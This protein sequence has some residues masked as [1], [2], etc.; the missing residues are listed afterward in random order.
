MISLF[1][2]YLTSWFAL[3]LFGLVL[4][5]FAISGVGNTSFGGLTSGGVASVGGS[6]ISEARLLGEFD[7]TLR[8]ARQADPKLDARTAA[9][10]GAVREVY[11]QLI[12]TT[13]I[14]KF[15][16]DQ[17]I[18]I[19]DRAIDGE[20]ASVEAFQVNGV[21]DQA[22]YT[23]LLAAQRLSERD[24][25]DGLRS[26]LI[27]KQVVVPVVA[28]VK[29]P[30]GLAEPYAALLLEKREG[31]VAVVPAAA[32]AA[33]AAPTTAQLSAFYAAHAA[34]Y[35]LPER[36][37]FR[38]ALLD[39]AKLA[40][41]VTISDADVARYFAAN[42]ETYAGAETRKLLQVV[43]PDEAKAKAVAGAI[44]G[45]KSFGAAAAAA[46]FAA[47]DIDIGAQTRAKFAAATSAA[48]ADAAFALHAGGV[49][50]P[51]QSPF[52]WH[53]VSVTA[54]TPAQPRTLAAARGEIVARLT[55]DRT[56]ALLS[57]TVGKIEEALSS[58]TTL[59]DAAKRFGLTVVAVPPVT[60]AGSNPADAGFTLAPAAAPLVAKA[61]DAD[62]ADGPALQQLDKA[63]FAILEVGDV[64]PPAPVA[65][66]KVRDAVTVAYLADARLRAAKAVAD[67]IV[68]E[69]A[70]GR[71][72]ASVVIAHKLPPVRPLAGRPIDLNRAAGTPPPVRAFLALAAGASRAVT[73]GAQGWWI[74]HVD[75][76]TPG[77]PATAPQLVDS[78]RAQFQQAAPDELGSAFAQAVTRAVGVRRNPA[79]LAA[80]TARITGT[81]K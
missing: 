11:E 12:A 49:T 9:R 23:R 66:A 41:G 73:A 81:A 47:T 79:A 26:D 37:A 43:V 18:A 48:V 70:K 72:F 24:L 65:L 68:A 25:R 74:V 29:V 5:A 13:A 4:V 56:E 1:R 63:H 75:T 35:T 39:G 38:Y 55:A 77:D 51:V 67:T 17:G 46:G 2:K 21:F 7:R 33:P 62:P 8:R 28:G 34:A 10:Q 54:I 76:V 3:A 6:D 53:L 64:V 22:T 14:E 50:A 69:V 80:A 36:R 30:R 27:R 78:A 16:R 19:S 61:F 15:A 71:P 31:A 60:R 32:M 52:G 42:V 44:A 57:D 20:I 58:R 40:A 59:A 45:G